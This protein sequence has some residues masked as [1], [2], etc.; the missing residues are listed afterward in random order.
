MSAVLVGQCS[1]TRLSSQQL[2]SSPNDC[3]QIL[4]NYTAGKNAWGPCLAAK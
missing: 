1:Q 3:L 4:S 2:P